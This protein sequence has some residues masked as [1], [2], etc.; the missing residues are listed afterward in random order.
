MLDGAVFV[1]VFVVLAIVLALNGVK[2]Y[3]TK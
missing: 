2:C 3:S 1:L